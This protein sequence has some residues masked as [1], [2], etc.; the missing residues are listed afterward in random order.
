MRVQLPPSAPS[1]PDKGLFFV[2]E[3][4]QSLHASSNMTGEMTGDELDRPRISSVWI[5]ILIVVG[6]LII[7]DLNQRMGDARRLDR[8]ARS[9]ETVITSLETENAILYT[10][11]A[12]VTSEVLISEWAHEE[13]GLVREGE[14]LVV[15]LAPPES[16]PVF[17]P[18]PTPVLRQPS[19]WEVWWAL[20]FGR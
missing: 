15:P 18:T 8:D 11:V 13:G 19:N 20:L 3:G 10:Q 6:I 2:M 1:A 12:Q 9:L 17:M 7:G 5:V 14:V 4:L 16:A